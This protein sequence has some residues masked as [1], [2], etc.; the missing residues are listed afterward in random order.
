M[1]RKRTEVSTAIVRRVLVV[2]RNAENGRVIAQAIQPWMFET[3]VCSS[4]Q[5]SKELLE[6]KDFALIFCEDREE[7]A[8]RNLLSGV[9]GNR[10]TPPVVVMISDSNQEFVFREAMAL[11]ALGVVTSPCSTKD[12]QWMVIRAAENGSAGRRSA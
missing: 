7:G 4:L 9:R 8:Y 2:S 12:V 11:G 10:K 6:R 5:E 3:V 1:G